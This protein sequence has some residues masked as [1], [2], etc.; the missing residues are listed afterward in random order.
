VSSAI[1]GYVTGSTTQYDSSSTVKSHHHAHRHSTSETAPEGQP[2]AANSAQFSQQ[3]TEYLSG[4]QNQNP[5]STDSYGSDSSDYA[6]TSE[7]KKSLLTDL[8]SKLNSQTSTATSETESNTADQILAAL[9]NELSGFDASKATD[10]QISSLFDQ[11]A[12]SL[13]SSR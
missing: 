1:T 7:Q 8:Q 9:K 2:T 4:S 11:V 10:E 3:M 5:L 12:Q 13:A 6:L